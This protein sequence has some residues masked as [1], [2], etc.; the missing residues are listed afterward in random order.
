MR[1]P[2]VGAG[3]YALHAANPATAIARGAVTAMKAR[4]RR[5]A[6]TPAVSGIAIADSGVAG[7]GEGTNAGFYALGHWHARAV[8]SVGVFHRFQLCYSSASER[9][10]QNSRDCASARPTDGA[11]QQPGK[12]AN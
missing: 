8:G 5:A 9:R 4:L 7:G 10:I 2:C 3:L 12:P 6:P 1:L 11:P